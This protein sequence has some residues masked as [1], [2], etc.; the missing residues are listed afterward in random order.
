[1]TGFPDRRD[2][3]ATGRTADVWADALREEFAG[4]SV[5]ITGHTEFKGSWLAL[6]LR[7]LGA[8]VTGYALD[9]PTV[10]S[11]FVAA[12]VADAMQMDQRADIRN[13]TALEGRS[14]PADP[15]SSFTWLPRVWSSRDMRSPPKPSP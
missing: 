13:R 8:N 3:S 10:P 5:L 12:A 7:E 4:R 6:W 11:N 2:A 14:G 9:P 15:M 1:M